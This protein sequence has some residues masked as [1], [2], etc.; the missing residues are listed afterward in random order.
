[1]R[2]QTLKLFERAERSRRAVGLLDVPALSA[3][4]GVGA[5]HR[6]EVPAVRALDRGG[7]IGDQRL[8]E[9]VLSRAAFA[10]DIHREL[11]G[12]ESSRARAE[13]S[14]LLRRRSALRQRAS[15]LLEGRD[16]RA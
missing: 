7:A 8:V 2:D 10:G 1:G 14:A 4:A 16:R 12:A 9:R 5:E 15:E 13:R 11:R 6:E 3:G